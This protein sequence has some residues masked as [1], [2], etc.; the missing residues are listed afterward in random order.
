MAVK[1]QGL[2]KGLGSL[3]GDMNTQA[4]LPEIREVTQEEAKTAQMIRIRDIEP[5]RN[6][7]RHHFSEEELQELSDS[8]RTYGVITPLI[9]VKADKHYMIIA[10]ERRWR[11]AKLAGLKEVPAVIRDY[12]EREIAEISLVENIQRTDLD[13]VEE[14]EAYDRIMKTYDLTQE[15]LSDRIGKSRSAVA[16][17]LRLLNLPEDVRKALAEGRLS[18]GHAKV[19]LSLE[20]PLKMSDA[21]SEIL[22]KGLSVRDTEKLV[23]QLKNPKKPAVRAPLKNQVEYENAENSL[24][25]LLKTKVKI[26]RRSENAGKIEIDFYSLEDIERILRHIS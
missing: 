18:T 8:I 14:A 6:Q 5:N 21:A 16:N 26:N 15:A 9:L 22:E 19:I 24:S 12:T 20:D 13:P 25:E 1:R 11:A 3:L 4:K 17:S 2:G 23:K 7:P 10:G